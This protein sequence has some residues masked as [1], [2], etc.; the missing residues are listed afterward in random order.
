MNA[1]AQKNLIRSVASSRDRVLSTADCVSGKYC[2]RELVGIVP[3]FPRAATQEAVK[4][5]CALMYWEHAKAW[6]PKSFSTIPG[7]FQI[8]KQKEISGA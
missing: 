2:Y 4:P 3:S 5:Q 1:N 8:Y 6:N 7:T